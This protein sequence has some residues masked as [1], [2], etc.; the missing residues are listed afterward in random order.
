MRSFSSSN[1]YCRT[2]KTSCLITLCQRSAAK[3]CMY[4]PICQA[5]NQRPCAVNYIR[6]DVTHYRSRCE[7]C[8]RK[9]RGLKPR[10][11]RWQ[12]AGYKKKPA[13]DRCGFKARFLSQLM[14]VHVDS[15]LNNCEL[16]NLRTVC[17]NCVELLKK[18]DST[19]RPGD[20][21]PDS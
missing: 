16:R 5:C 2:E 21:L 10:E 12:K 15:N 8:L 19:W 14:V 1:I 4:R 20:L 17:L 6:E 13:C 11:P 3:Y 18:T 9:G 7:T